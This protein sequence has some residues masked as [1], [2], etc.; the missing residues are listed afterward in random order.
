MEDCL[1]GEDDD[2]DRQK[3]LWAELVECCEGEAASAVREAEK[4]NG[5]GAY[6]KLKERFQSTSASQAASMIKG[7]LEFK[8][9]KIKTPEHVTSW[10]ELL[11]RLQEAN[12]DLKFNHTMICVLFL[13]SLNSHMKPF[14]TYQMMQEKMEPT[15]VYLGAIE[16]EQGQKADDDEASTAEVAMWSHEGGADYGSYSGKGKGKG[17]DGKGKGKGYDGKGKGKGKGGK[18]RDRWDQGGDPPCGN[19]GTVGHFYRHCWEPCPL[20]WSTQ[21]KKW[22]CPDKVDKKREHA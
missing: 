7:V 14:V 5:E 10:K 12:K 1:N 18:G 20:C 19:C 4:G 6:E 21:H 3:G 9:G 13:Q 8:Q 17:Y 15:K 16:F 2:E 11:R 22:D